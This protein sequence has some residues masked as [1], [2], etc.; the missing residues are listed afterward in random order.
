V[1]PACLV[2]EKYYPGCFAPVFLPLI[3]A[4]F[5]LP[6]EMEAHTYNGWLVH[7]F[8]SQA[9]P[10][11]IKVEP[12]LESSVFPLFSPPSSPQRSPTESAAFS[13][14]RRRSNTSIAN[15]KRVKPYPILTR[16]LHLSGGDIDT[17]ANTWSPPGSKGGSARA[18]FPVEQ[19][20]QNRRT[21]DGDPQVS[22]YGPFATVG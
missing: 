8:P 6:I 3:L 7:S 18:H 15:S 13:S 12:A 20:S 4:P 9:R 1:T 5:A 14:S 2:A 17:M 10:V 21:S 16:E 11:D 19:A 22:S